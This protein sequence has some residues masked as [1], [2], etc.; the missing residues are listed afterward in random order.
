MDWSTLNSSSNR[1]E[2][3]PRNSLGPGVEIKR[4]SWNAGMPVNVAQPPP[5]SPAAW[6]ERR[7][8]R[9]TRPMSPTKFLGASSLQP[10]RSVSGNAFTEKEGLGAPLGVESTPEHDELEHEYRHGHSHEHSHEHNHEHDH[11]SHD[12][13][14]AHSYSSGIEHSN[15]HEHTHNNLSRANSRGRSHAHS[16]EHSHD[17]GAAPSVPSVPVLNEP[18][19]PFGFTPTYVDQSPARPRAS[20][21]RGHHY[22]H[23]SVSLNF[24][25]EPEQRAP[26]AIPVS[27]AVPTLAEYWQSITRPQFTRLMWCVFRMVVALAVY[28]LNTDVHA[29]APLAHL[30]AYETVVSTTAACVGI[31]AN[32]DVW[33]KSSV[34]LPFALKRAEAL[35]AFGLAA[36]LLFI[37]GD[38]ISHLIQHLVQSDNHHDHH[39]H[40]DHGAGHPSKHTSHF[41]HY[42][43]VLVSILTIFPSAVRQRSSNP[44]ALITLLF[45]CVVLVV[46]A[47]PESLGRFVDTALTPTIAI[48]MISVGWKTAKVFGGMLVMSYGGP[49]PNQEI[50]DQITAD[51]NVE[52]VSDISLWQVHHDLWLASMRIVVSGTSVDDRRVRQLAEKAVKSAV[53][54]DGEWETTIEIVKA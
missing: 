46:P 24:F 40:H 35:V 31:L 21:R 49:D 20:Q 53:D 41:S 32:F 16:S 51:P 12:H 15:T 6:Q 10:I 7:R 50:V 29:V 45:A 28:T 30:L 34:R 42:A 14:H 18:K 23:S 52:E 9:P 33:N 43:V 17:F 13:S 22:K 48:A 44:L 39:D 47:L 5:G 38:V 54:V 19:N 1:G 8:S 27:L 36:V 2:N 3:D 4:S 37:G 11:Q 26:L 25:Q